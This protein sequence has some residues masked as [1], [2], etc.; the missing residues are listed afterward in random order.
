VRLFTRNGHDW[1][2]RYR[3]IVE[4]AP[5]NRSTSFVID[6]EA[7][8]LGV[9][10]VPDFDR[11][12]SR[13]HD[14]EVHLYAAAVLNGSRLKGSSDRRRELSVRK[15][16]KGPGSSLSDAEILHAEIVCGCLRPRPRF[17]RC[18]LFGSEG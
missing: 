1:T 17:G 10:G 11:L 4:A 16:V 18:G 8:L 3:P 5:K 7:V 15:D 12:H 13:Q 9:D 6:G 2:D 14:D